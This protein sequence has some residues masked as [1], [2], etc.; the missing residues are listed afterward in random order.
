MRI[1]ILGGAFDPVHCDHVRMAADSLR[2]GF[3]DQVWMVPSPDR[4]DKSPQTAAYHRLAMLD[5]ALKSYAGSIIASDVEVGFGAFRGTYHLLKRLKNRYPEHRFF[6]LVGADSVKGIPSWRD[7][8]EY[9]GS[10]PNGGLLLSEFTLLVYPRTGF[11]WDVEKDF[12][13]N[14]FLPPLLFKEQVTGTDLVPPGEVASRNLRDRLWSDPQSRRFLPQGVW[15]YIQDK[16][17]YF[18]EG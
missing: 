3:V 17:L 1:A 8:E 12:I 4:W 2:F 6:L 9:N 14:G 11:S 5:I 15:E 13:A 16:Q 7:P 10:N 18:S